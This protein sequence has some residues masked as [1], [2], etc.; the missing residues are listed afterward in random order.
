[1]I[2]YTQT[3]FEAEVGRLTGGRGADVVYDSV[4]AATFLKSLGSLRPRGM[5]VSFG[6]ASGAAPPI[7]PLLLSQKGSL[8]LTRPNLAHY[9]ATRPELLQRASDVL[10]WVASGKLKVRIHKSY[11]LAEAAQALS[12]QREQTIENEQEQ[13]GEQEECPGLSMSM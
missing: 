3:D 8:F 6:N 13:A 4:G 12:A 1:V 5:M 7:E 11:P 10:T 2:L 9:T